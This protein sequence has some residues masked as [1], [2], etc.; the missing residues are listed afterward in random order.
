[1]Y[2]S[3]LRKMIGSVE[4]T[5]FYDVAIFYLETQKYRELSIID[6][7]GDGGRDVSCSRKDLRIQLSVRRD[8]EKK[9]N[10]E[11]FTTKSQ[12]LHHL[13]YV[14]NKAIT[15]QA[16]ANFRASKFSLSGEVD[17]SIHDL[18][19]ISTALSRPGRIKRAYEMMGASISMSLHASP[20]DIAISS[21]LLFGQE[22]SELR[23]EIIG[24]NIKAWLLSNPGASEDVL[25]DEVVRVLP[26]A[27]PTK[28]VTSAINRL[29]TSGHV[30][31]SKSNM[32]LSENEAANMKAAQDEFLYAR[33]IDIN[34]IQ[35]IT[36]LSAEDADHLLT[37]AT[38][39]LIRG[40]DFNGNDAATEEIRA[41]LANK[42]LTR[43][44]ANIY[45]VLSACSIAK[46]FQYA[47]TVETVFAT[48]TFD[49]YRALGNRTDITMVL[50]TSVALP[51][52]FGLEFRVANS[53]YAV[54]ASTLLEVC[55]AHGFKIIVPRPYVNEMAS[56]G[57][58]AIEFIEIYENLPDEL[59]PVLRGSGNA[60][61]SHFSH[62]Q[63]AVEQSGNEISLLA[64]L[65]AFG[66]RK[67]ASLRQV[68]NKMIS[69]LESHSINI[70]MNSYYD[71]DVRR[72]I[73][74]K[75]NPYESKYI[76][77]HDAAVCTT[78]IN[79]SEKGYIFAT[80][81]KVL[82]GIVQDLARVYADS[83]ARVIDFLSLV[84]GVDYEYDVTTELLT[85]LLHID[86]RYAERLSA[87]LEKIKS[88][89]Q[90][91]KLR[92]FIDDARSIHGQTWMPDVDDLTHFLDSTSP[93]ETTDSASN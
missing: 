76:L 39:I 82:I 75:K 60:F 36:K 29:R 92:E 17:V 16:E 69:L 83:P 62:I 71:Q 91:F 77:D 6:G 73:A 43:N 42:K 72:Q 53:R 44:R 25:V 20:T 23:Q 26:G 70:A 52:L 51:M 3:A 64:F 8:W 85:T 35:E 22:A 80:W 40:N 67:D 14:T 89:S 9:I 68:E 90:A 46:Q 50:D 33:T 12:K 15:P 87:K 93:E 27:D 13:V 48:N 31:G 47:K 45:K 54:A 4:E 28:A 63:E 21:I 49:I 59:K 37:L 32:S 61:L 58:R 84:E 41:F 79:E 88:P 34:N 19:R 7:T 1:M 81:D 86:E 5:L 57:L 2:F 66:I 11:A 56:H 30:V 78:L 18:N 24:A 10:E 55:R 74:D 38:E 65:R